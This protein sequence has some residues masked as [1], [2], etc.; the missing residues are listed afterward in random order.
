MKLFIFPFFAGSTA[1]ASNWRILTVNQVEWIKE[2][3]QQIED[4]GK[5]Y[6]RSLQEIGEAHMRVQIEVC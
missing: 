3:Q 5:L 1:Y 4:L 2:N 6:G